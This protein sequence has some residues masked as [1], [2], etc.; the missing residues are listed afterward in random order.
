[1]QQNVLSNEPPIALFVKDEN[2]LLFY[3][4]IADLAKKHLTKNGILYFEINQYLSAETVDLLKSKGF[5]NI[6]M[7][8][9][10][11]GVDRMVK[12]SRS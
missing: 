4:K 7:K 2:P 9:D 5:K 1:M 12:C 10:I 11:Y 8:K 6:E 3:H